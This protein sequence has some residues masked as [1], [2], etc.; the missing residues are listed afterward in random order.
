MSNFNNTV[1]PIAPGLDEYIVGA[2]SVEQMIQRLQDEFHS[3]IQ[4]QEN[5]II[6]L[7]SEIAE[8]KRS[9][10]E[11]DETVTDINSEMVKL[12]RWAVVTVEEIN[13]LREMIEND[14][15]DEL[16]RDMKAKSVEYT[17]MSRVFTRDL[18]ELCHIRNRIVPK[19]ERLIHWMSTQ[20]DA[21]RFLEENDLN[22]S[23][24]F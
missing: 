9:Q 8:L 5:Q 1:L 22:R 2:Y 10:R 19:M 11:S 15:I 6:E 3:T 7:Q 18:A 17:S 23:Q 20:P 4:R 13:E 24:Q 14:E 12:N 16:K 21:K